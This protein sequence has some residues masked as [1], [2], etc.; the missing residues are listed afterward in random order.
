MQAQPPQIHALPLWAQILSLSVALFLALLRAIE[1]FKVPELYVRLTRDMFFRLI[2]DGEALFCHAVL[3]A[4]NGPVL[5]REINLKLKRKGNRAR[6]EKLFPIQILRFGEKVK[7]PALLAEH[8][9]FSS[10][11]LLYL[12]ENQPMRAVYLGVQREYHPRQR[13]AV[14]NFAARIIAL[15]SNYS[16]LS[17]EA[18]DPEVAG[19]VLQELDGIINDSSREMVGLVQL[20]A[21]EYEV[22][23]DVTYESPGSRLWKNRGRSNSTISFTVEEQPLSTWKAQLNGVLRATAKNTLAGSDDRIVYPEF[24]PL[25]FSESDQ[26]L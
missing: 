26:E 4:R 18:I 20:E 13:R 2:E 15:K 5:I 8:H 19:R 9:F 10:S 7:G 12:P 22:E 21:G 14:E 25:E 11:P 1:F 23:I 16:Q 24:Q 17:T 6:A 3:L